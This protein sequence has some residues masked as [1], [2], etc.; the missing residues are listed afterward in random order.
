MPNIYREKSCPRCGKRHRKKRNFCS[1]ECGN[2][3]R[4]VSEQHKEANRQYMRE[5]FKSPEGVAKL[6][7]WARHDY[8]VKSEDFYISIPEIKESP[9]VED[10]D[11]WQS[12]D[13]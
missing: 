12:T 5:F 2:S 13:W 8:T 10:G 4:V 3:G 1:R 11:I 7:Q 9:S 6:N